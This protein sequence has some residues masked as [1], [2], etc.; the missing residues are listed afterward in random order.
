MATAC[1]MASRFAGSAAIP[2][3]PIRMAM[4]VP[5]AKEAASVNATG[6]YRLAIRLLVALSYGVINREQYASA[7]D[8]NR[9]RA[10]NSGRRSDGGAAVRQLLIYRLSKFP[11]A[12]SRCVMSLRRVER[13][14]ALGGADDVH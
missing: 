9:D 12:V 8:V 13:T 7:F 10:I 2:C 11:S 3:A 14:D 5:T 1:R 6:A 4:N